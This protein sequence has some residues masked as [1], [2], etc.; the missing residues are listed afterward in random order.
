[1]DNPCDL[2]IDALFGFGFSG[3]PKS[4]YK[5]LISWMKSCGKPIVSVDVPS[6]WPVDGAPSADHIKP[7]MLVSLSAPVHLLVKIALTG[8]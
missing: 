3:E 5:E 7:E 1:M 2:V 6:G 8:I 4:P